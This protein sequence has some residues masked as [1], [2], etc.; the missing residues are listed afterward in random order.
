[1]S[2]ESAIKFLSGAVEEYGKKVLHASPETEE[3]LV[4]EIKKVRTCTAKLL[5]R[6]A[7]RCAV[8]AQSWEKMTK[9]APTL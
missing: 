3:Y 7:S 5:A 2:R 8:D 4:E 1:M 9:H 6:R